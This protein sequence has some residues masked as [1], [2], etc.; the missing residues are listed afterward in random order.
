MST[1]SAA[2]AVEIEN[3]P[4]VPE[5]AGE[6]QETSAEWDGS[7]TKCSLLV[8]HSGAHDDGCL[9]WLSE[10]AESVEA[11]FAPKPGIDMVTLRRLAAVE[12][13]RTALYAK[14]ASAEA[15]RDAYQAN[16]AGL[17]EGLARVTAERDESTTIAN[18][19][20][21]YGKA[22]AA[23]VIA[24]RETPNDLVETTMDYVAAERALRAAVCPKA[25]AEEEDLP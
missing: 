25:L 10:A 12:D 23:W 22:Y 3:G 15:D 8:G 21:A 6:C 16:V 20:R 7:L 9:T 17:T 1:G 13:Q 18:L 4:P 14:L 24:R 2:A 19:A 5:R 11:T